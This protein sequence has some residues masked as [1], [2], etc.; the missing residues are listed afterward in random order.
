MLSSE[1]H[2]SNPCANQLS[3]VYDD[4]AVLASGTGIC[5]DSV[6]RPRSVE[7]VANKIHPDYQQL[8]RQANCSLTTVH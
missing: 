6:T 5:F 1:L 8:K 7:E 2:M 3:R 4:D